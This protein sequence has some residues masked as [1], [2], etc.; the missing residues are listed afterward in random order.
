MQN[1]WADPGGYDHKSR[2]VVPVRYIIRDGGPDGPLVV[3]ET[4]QAQNAFAGTVRASRVF[5]S[6]AEADLPYAKLITSLVQEACAY[7][8]TPTEGL[9]V[10]VPVEGTGNED[11]DDEQVVFEL[12]PYVPMPG[13][14]TLSPGVPDDEVRMRIAR[15]DDGENSREAASFHQKRYPLVDLPWPVQRAL[16][17]RIEQT[18]RAWGFRFLDEMTDLDVVGRALEKAAAQEAHRVVAAAQR[19]ATTVMATAQSKANM[20]VIIF[21]CMSSSPFRHKF[22][23]TENTSMPLSFAALIISRHS[24][25]ERPALVSSGKI[26]LSPS[27]RPSIIFLSFLSC[28][29]FVPDIFSSTKCTF[30]KS[31]SLANF[32]ISALNFSLS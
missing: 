11:G 13:V 23:L 25:V 24:N 12:R 16:I 2:D 22:S 29:V 6:L 31:R 17:E 32:R 20:V 26:N 5:H 14:P 4:R 30:P 28:H 27:P 18:K 1:R 15:I 10:E 3:H 7:F 9:W 8:Y 19:E 21:V